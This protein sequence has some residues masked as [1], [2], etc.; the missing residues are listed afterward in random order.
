MVISALFP[1]RL[2]LFSILQQ[3][4]IF[5]N[6]TAERLR[7]ESSGNIGIGTNDPKHYCALQENN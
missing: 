2:V 3:D 1:E 4:R 7:I 5:Y 6:G